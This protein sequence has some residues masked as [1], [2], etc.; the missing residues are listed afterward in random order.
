MKRH[1]TTYLTGTT[2]L[3]ALIGCSDGGLGTAGLQ[4]RA[5]SMAGPAGGGTLVM[6]DDRQG[7]F[8]LVTAHLA[9]RDIKLDLPEGITCAD[10][11]ADLVGAT[12]EPATALGEE[13]TIEIAGPFTVDLVTG[14]AEPGLDDIQIPALTYQRIDFRVDGQGDYGFVAAADFE[15]DGSP[16][17]LELALDFSED[18]R[19]ESPEG[20]AVD[21]DTDLIA[22]FVVDDWLAG[23]SIS[24]CVADDSDVL[25]GSTVRIDESATSGSCSGIENTVKDNMKRS[26]QLDRS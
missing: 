6:I 1:I 7:E 5:G 11:E 16:A 8:A 23:V 15:L 18:I 9:L 20:V 10:V 3:F 4:V 2:C 14:A 17:R 24:D 25:E 26:G 21:S 22:E 19:I 12:C 13:D